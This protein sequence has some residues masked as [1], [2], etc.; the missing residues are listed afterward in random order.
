MF[1][2]GLFKLLHIISL[3]IVRT[4]FY[5]TKSVPITYNTISPGI[6]NSKTALTRF[7]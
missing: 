6:Y 4:Y 3:L 2:I 7:L 5:V 1:S